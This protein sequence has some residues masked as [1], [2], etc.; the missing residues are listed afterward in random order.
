M[1]FLPRQTA[2]IVLPLLLGSVSK[3][4]NRKRKFDPAG[5][6]LPQFPIDFR[7]CGAKN[8]VPIDNP[9]HALFEDIG[10]KRSRYANGSRH[11]EGRTI[12][13]DPGKTPKSQLADASRQLKGLNEIVILW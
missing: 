8:C 2:E 1:R 11:V 3:V 4:A 5:N 6:Q 12:R 13:H 7:E 10:R 9:L